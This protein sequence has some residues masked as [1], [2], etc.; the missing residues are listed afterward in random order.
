MQVWIEGPVGRL[1][2]ELWEPEGEP[3]AVIALCHPHP[4]HGGTMSNNV[5]HRAGRA[6]QEAGIAVLRFDF[7]GVR[8]SEGTHD[9]H[10]AEEG[11]LGAAL[12]WLE[13]R[14]PGKALWAG[15][16]SFGSRT[17]VGFLARNPSRVERVLLIALPVL[18][19]TV[20]EAAE[21]TLPG[22]ALMAGD[23][24]FGTKQAL[25]ARFPQLETRLEI[26]EIEGVDHFFTGALDELR[27]RVRDWA[28]RSTAEI[29]S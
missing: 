21:L 18:A 13:D 11:D 15:G 19:Y 4:A 1:H 16:F 12:A 27:N 6:L 9:G 28:R 17:T 14:F 10:G 7:R 8:R 5:V 29:Q 26:D 20:D 2:G 22:L 3:K 25:L 24:T 23:D